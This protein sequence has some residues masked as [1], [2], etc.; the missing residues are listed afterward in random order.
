VNHDADAL[1]P[2][3]LDILLAPTDHDDAVDEDRVGGGVCLAP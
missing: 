1:H 2:E 3:R